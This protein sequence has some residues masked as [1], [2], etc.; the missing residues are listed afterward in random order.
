MNNYKNNM[1]L[2]GNTYRKEYRTY[3]SY[4]LNYFEEK[5]LRNYK[6]PLRKLF[7]VIPDNSLVSIYKKIKKN[8]NK[9]AFVEDFI[10]YYFYEKKISFD[11]KTRKEKRKKE[12]KEKVKNR[13]KKFRETTKKIS[14]QCLIN[15]DLKKELDKIKKDKNFTYEQLLEYLVYS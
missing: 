7:R 13:V 9:P 10:H 2:V 11:I 1:I 3:E 6:E 4:I 15:S 12:D 8:Y 14:F 5:N